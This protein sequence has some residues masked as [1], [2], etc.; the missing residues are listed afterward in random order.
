MAT[1]MFCYSAIHMYLP[2]P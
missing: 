1:K 2:T